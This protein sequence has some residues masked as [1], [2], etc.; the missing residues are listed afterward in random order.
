MQQT[1]VWSLGW[2]DPLEK[3]KATHSSI[4]AWKIPRTEEPGG[5]LHFMELQRVE[6]D[7][8]H[9]RAIAF[10]NVFLK[11]V[12]FCSW[13]PL[14]LPSLVPGRSDGKESAYNAGDLDSIPGSGKSHGEGN[15]NPLQYSC[16]ENPMD[17]GAW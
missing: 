1:R 16:L 6:H 5:G 8:A 7:W 13:S 2:E 14:D 11:T 12:L 10:Y 17:G 4:L 9:A 15:D 3:G